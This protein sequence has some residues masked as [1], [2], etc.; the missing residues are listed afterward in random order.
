MMGIC[1]VD[2]CDMTEEMPDPVDEPMAPDDN[3][4]PCNEFPTCEPCLNNRMGCVW[5]ADSCQRVCD[6]IADAA[7]YSAQNF[8]NMTGPEICAIAAEPVEGPTDGGMP[9]NM[10]EEVPENLP[11][12]VP[13]SEPGE[14]NVIHPALQFFVCGASF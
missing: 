6:V 4:E 12:E 5:I 14:C 13:D 2:T 1:P 9:E 7:C 11:E 8:P 10:P 3:M